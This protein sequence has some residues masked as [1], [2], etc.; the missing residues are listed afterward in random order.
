MIGTK[1]KHK[2]LGMGTVAALDADAG[3][4]TVDFPD[5]P[6]H[7]L[8][9]DIFESFL[10]AGNP[11]I[12]A[13]LLAAIKAK[14]D[15]AA[16]A[17][18]EKARAVIISSSSPVKRSGLT[19]KKPPAHKNL[20]IKCNYCDGGASR[21]KLGYTGIC[22]KQTMIYNVQIDKRPW[23]SNDRCACNR[24]LKGECSYEDVVA[25]MKAVGSLCYETQ[26]L[27]EWTAYMGWNSAGDTPMKLPAAARTNSL[28]VLTTRKP[29]AKE[30]D[31][32]V[33]GVFL[34]DYHE[35]GGGDSEGL[36]TAHPRYRISLTPEEAHKTLLW[37]YYANPNK[38]LT[39]RWGTGL[40]RLLDDDNAAALLADIVKLKQGKQDGVLAKELYEHFCTLNSINAS[41]PPEASGALR[42]SSR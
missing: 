34:V 33:F 16:K 11:A 10:T 30:E 31:R 9:P 32:F 19:R 41:P 5:R 6:Y 26:L 13:E 38:P 2:T 20:I 4:I 29:Y 18:P 28:V 35:E 25:E 21:D 23:C 14:K 15:A 7:F 22:S 17:E 12:Q 24:Y 42:L 37:D 40:T 39:M 1:V 36:V 3:K 27:T 8:Y